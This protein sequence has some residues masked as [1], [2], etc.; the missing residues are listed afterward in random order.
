MG[1]AAAVLLIASLNLANM[2]LARGTARTKEIALRLA[3]GASR[4]RII[5]QLLCE[6]FLLAVAG[7]EL[8]ALDRV[9]YHGK[10]GSQGDASV[11][12]SGVDGDRDQRDQGDD[13]R[14]QE[15]R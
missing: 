1:M 14:A 2:L 7:D 10:L 12:G 8:P 11:A 3:L 15:D 4:W 13:G 6:G 5:R 9:V